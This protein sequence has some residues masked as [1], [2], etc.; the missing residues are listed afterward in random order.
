ML[1]AA[2]NLKQ[3]EYSSVFLSL[4]KSPEERAERRKLVEQMKK[5]IA[6]NPHKKYF[7]RQGEICCD[8]ETLRQLVPSGRKEGDKDMATPVKHSGGHH[9]SKNLVPA[10][11]EGP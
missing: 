7:I 10:Q 3:S 1:K 9:L 4:D 11:Q 6:E 5:K 8:E 2:K